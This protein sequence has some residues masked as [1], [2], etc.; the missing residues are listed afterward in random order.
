MR[1]AHPYPPRRGAFF[2]IALFSCLQILFG[3]FLFTGNGQ[4]SVLPVRPSMQIAAYE[5]Y[6][7]YDFHDLVFDMSKIEPAAGVMEEGVSNPNFIKSTH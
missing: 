5:R 4:D 3:F 2:L 7:S 1:F 6:D